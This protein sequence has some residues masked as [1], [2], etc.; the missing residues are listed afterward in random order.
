MNP[1]VKRVLKIVSFV[2]A[3]AILITIAVFAWRFALDR[4]GFKAWMDEHG[5]MGAIAYCLMVVL[6]IIVAIVPGG[7]IEIA[8]GYAFGALNGTV[9]FL[10]GSFTGSVLVFV[11]V[12][13][14]GRPV[15]EL[16]FKDKEIRKLSFLR[17]GRKRNLLFMILFIIPGSPKDLLCY[18]AGLTDMK[19]WFFALIASLGRLPAVIASAVSGEALGQ[20]NYTVAIVSIV[21]IL[22]LSGIGVLVY[23]KISSRHKDN[24][25]DEI[26]ESDNNG[27]ELP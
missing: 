2:I 14:F 6:Q 3:A 25:S 18:V 15:V 4:E 26:E 20:T 24:G 23:W 22:V 12:R 21:I 13:K 8:G 5:S 9:L 27:N 10:I 19:F 7:P 16:F 1:K 17:D 11:L